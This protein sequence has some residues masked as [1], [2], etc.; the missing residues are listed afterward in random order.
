MKGALEAP[1]AINVQNRLSPE[2]HC[3][4]MSRQIRFALRKE[5]CNFKHD[6]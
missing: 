3:L 1:F 5:R 4:S 2:K 6:D